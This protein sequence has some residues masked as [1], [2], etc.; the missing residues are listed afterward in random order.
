[1]Q[2]VSPSSLTE[3]LGRL[4]DLAADLAA[5]AESAAALRDVSTHVAQLTARGLRVPDERLHQLRDLEGGLDL[6]GMRSTV[7]DL[8]ALLSLPVPTAPVVP[9][10]QADPGP[11]SGF[12]PGATPAV[13]PQDTPSPTRLIELLTAELKLRGLHL[14]FDYVWRGDARDVTLAAHR[15]ED[16]AVAMAD[17]FSTTS[18]RTPWSTLFGM[19]VGSER[20]RCAARMLALVRTLP[21]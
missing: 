13:Q 5:L 17:G 2:H 15:N 11:A 10:T 19:R 3:F 4:S 14:H 1:M 12:V 21:R 20:Y 16:G 18:H 7:A 6:P 9:V 8:A